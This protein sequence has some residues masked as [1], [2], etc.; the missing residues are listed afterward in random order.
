MLEQLT[1]TEDDGYGVDD[2]SGEELPDPAGGLL[3]A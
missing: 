3:K 1:N 2:D